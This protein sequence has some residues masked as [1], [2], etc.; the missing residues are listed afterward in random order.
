[1]HDALVTGSDLSLQVFTMPQ[2]QTFVEPE[3]DQNPP[4]AGGTMHLANVRVQ[5]QSHTTDGVAV[6][7]AESYL[8]TELEKMV[9]AAMRDG[10]PLETLKAL[11]E[12]AWIA[13]TH[14]EEPVEVVTEAFEQSRLPEEPQL[15]LT[16]EAYQDTKPE[17][18]PVDWEALDSE[19][20]GLDDYAVVS[21]VPDGYGWR[22]V[23]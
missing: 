15:R 17:P 14:V 19:P 16:N 20:D 5:T 22:V 1:M 10:I 11:V 6:N 3:A 2:L 12:A 4:S 13:A 7:L 23:D 21:M 9:A 8:G 18:E